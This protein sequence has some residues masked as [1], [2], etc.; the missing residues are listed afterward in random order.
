MF[1]DSTSAGAMFADMVVTPGQGVS[2]QWRSSTGGSCGYA[3]LTGIA[4]PAWVELVRSGS[5][6]SG[7]YATTTGTPSA[8]NWIEVGTAQTIPMSSTAQAGLA[9]TSHDNGTL[10][11]ATFTGVQVATGPTVATAAAASPNPVTGTSTILSVLGTIMPG[12]PT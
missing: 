5:S 1:R 9:V 6:F 2:F 7:F 4:A 10:C 12:R 11:T 3:Q 8:S